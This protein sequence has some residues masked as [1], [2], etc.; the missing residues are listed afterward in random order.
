MKKMKHLFCVSVITALLFSIVIGVPCA[1]AVDIE[2][3]PAPDFLWE[4]DFN[5][6]TSF[7]DNRG[8]SQYTIEGTNVSLG[9]AHGKRALGITDKNGVYFINDMDKILD[10]YDT[11]SIEADMFFEKFPTGQNSGGQT[12]NEAPMSFVTW[13]TQNEGSTSTSYRSVRINED[14]YLCTGYGGDSKTEAKLPLG[15]W[16]NI[17]FLLSP[18]SGLC[19]VFI[20]GQKTL[21]YRLGAP[22]NMVLSRVRFFDIRFNYSVYFSNISVYSDSSYRIGLVKE[23]A[24][25]YLAYQTKKPQGNAFD[26]RLIA[27]INTENITAYSSTGFNVTTLWSENGKVKSASKDLSAETVYSSLLANGNTVSATSLGASY[28]TVIPLTGIP[29]DKGNVEIVVRPFIKKD[30]LR[31]YGEATILTYAGEQNGGY[32]VLSV[33]NRS[34]E[35][36]AYPSDDTF[37]RCDNN[38]NF[39]QSTT[40]E[41]KNGGGNDPYTREIYV[42]FT[43]SEAALKKL[44]ASNRI[45]F[46]FYVNS[47]RSNLTQEEIEEGGILADVC[48]VETNWSENELTGKNAPK[49][50]KEIRFIG[51]VRYGAKQYNRIDVTDYVLRHAEN[52]EV[53]FKITNVY[54]DG[55]S[56]R[57]MFA[58]S[59]SESGT[60]RLT[61]YPILY[62][63]EINLGKMKNPGYE[64]WGYAE[65]LVDQWFNDEYERAYANTYEPHDLETVNVSTPNGSHTVKT[66]QTASAPT[67]A[68]TAVKY[69]RTVDSL[70]GFEKGVAPEYDAYYGITNMGIKG[71]AT[72]YFHAQE[73]NGRC[74]IIDPLGNPF[75]AAGVNTLELGATDNQRAAA[76]E[77]YGSEEAFYRAVSEEL[78][79]SGINTY[80]GGDVGFFAE[81][82]LITAISTGCLSGY[83]NKELGLGA[84]TG[85]SAKYAN[86][87]TMNVFDPDFYT[88]CAKKTAET[89][90]PYKNGDRILGF[91]SD[92][93][94]PADNDM[95]YRYLTIDP[96]NPVN[97]FSY[98]AA[99]TWFI[100]ATGEANPTVY[101]ITPALSEQFKAFVYTNYF[102]AVTKALDDA[103]YGDYMY[104]GTRIH[105]E[106]ETSE[107]YLRAASQFVDVLSV[108]LYGGMEPP[109]ET[110]MTLYKYT[111]KPFLVTEFFA[112]GGDASDMNGYELGNQKNAGWQVDT[113]EDRGIHFENYTLL[114]L[115]S[116]TCVGWTWYRF[117]DND[118]SLYKDNV[119]NL[120]RAYDT[121]DGRISAFINLKTGDIIDGPS[122]APSLSVFYQGESDT[123]NLGSNKGLYDNKMNIYSALADAMKRISDNIPGLVSYFD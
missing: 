74:Y 99:W 76:I 63:H 105:N 18:S 123:S 107:G 95:L 88:Y 112:K 31:R 48:G 100:R 84:S 86:N 49:L 10:D 103:G 2:E 80:W 50:A 3:E 26:L 40:L 16:F 35:Y 61:V 66:M 69:A 52:G 8:S 68:T 116:K 101:N 122:L 23:E 54:P 5:K 51:E 82:K 93:E 94:L 17:R 98:A 106:N 58:S 7:D 72:G 70:L 27:G 45:Y 19:E 53:A 75:F 113:Q 83:M 4:L 115:E 97:A 47:H 121:A 34:V 108:N 59:E 71:D 29:T 111:G 14:G 37:V 12:P 109:A 90:A 32:P 65:K 38:E 42:K 96:T 64:P 114:L 92:N 104:M 25:D 6:M 11:F 56:G 73:I 89:V 117:R 120:Y 102:K 15:E 20:N 33:T 78:L 21:T 22:S 43:F 13:V 79:A 44:L 55:E 28:M 62:N 60:P 9:E 39:G 36:T 118:Q 41:L 91:V 87:N 119:G 1:H 46:E 24:A 30:G 57:M 77:K 81:N 67:S 85:G 110:I